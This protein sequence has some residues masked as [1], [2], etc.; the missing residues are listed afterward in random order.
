MDLG[1][2]SEALVTASPAL[3]VL[4]T[5][6]E[7]SAPALVP[8]VVTIS[9][10]HV[11][12]EVFAIAAG[13]FALVQCLLSLAVP[14]E[15]LWLAVIGLAVTRRSLYERGHDLVFARPRRR[16]ARGQVPALEA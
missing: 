12:V 1:I 7:L 15:L 2:V 5:E 8:A 4:A 13:L 10:P 3:P 16:R 9:T 14:S 6:A 11:S